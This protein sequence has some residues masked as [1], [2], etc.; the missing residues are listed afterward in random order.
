MNKLF[1][2][3]SL[4]VLCALVG[5]AALANVKSKKVHFNDDVTVAGTVVKK[6]DYK[7]S[8]DS[9]SKELTI[10]DGKQIVVKT[11]ASLDETKLKSSFYDATY[12]TKKESGTL[13]LT[14]VNVGGAFAVIGGEGSTTSTTTAQ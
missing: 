11:K 10:S 14:R 12:N 1:R 2:T 8:Y 9:E 3:L 5:G 4:V 6:G 13:L 7:V